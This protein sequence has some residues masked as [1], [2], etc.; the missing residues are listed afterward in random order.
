[1]YIH[2]AEA[3]VHTD[4]CMWFRETGTH[5]LRTHTPPGEGLVPCETDPVKYWK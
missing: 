4:A 1:M 2:A 3:R 5:Q